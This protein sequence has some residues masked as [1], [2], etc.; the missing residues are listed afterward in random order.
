MLVIDASVLAVALLDDGPD[1]DAARNRLHGEQLTAPALID[2]EVVSVWRGLAH[3]DPRRVG[4]A[5]DDLRDLPIQRVAHA[6]LLARCWELRDRPREPNPHPPCRGRTVGER[7]GRRHLGHDARE[8]VHG[9]CLTRWG[10]RHVERQRASHGLFLDRD[11]H[12]ADRGVR[13]DLDRTQRRAPAQKPRAPMAAASMATVT[14]LL[15]PPM[16][17]PPRSRTEVCAVFARYKRRGT[18]PP[19]RVGASATPSRRASVADAEEGEAW[20]RGATLFDEAGVTERVPIPLP[21]SG[22]V[23]L[24]RR[25]RDEFLDSLFG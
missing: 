2:L 3:L 23:D 25:Q 10:H 18:C 12:R 22:H 13:C 16:A 19:R 14:A 8:R 24:P 4:F 6:P 20:R 5:L 9:E 1:G 21:L 17:P 15:M 7:L 11:H